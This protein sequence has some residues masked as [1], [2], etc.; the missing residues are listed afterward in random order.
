MRT[1]PSLNA[2]RAFDAAGRLLSFQLAA[3]ELNVTPAAISWQVRLLEDQLGVMLFERGHRPVTLTP[4]GRQYLSDIVQAFESIRT[5]TINLT[6]AG[7]HRTLKIRAYTTFSM[8]WLLPR[9]T[10]FHE[11]HPD[12]EVTLTTS[13]QPVDFSSEDV[14]GAIR[15][16]RPP[17][18]LAF[19][20]LVPNRLRPVCS[21]EFLRMHETLNGDCPDALRHVALLHSLARRDD[22]AKWLDAA[23]VHG[24]NPLA[25]LSYESSTLAYFGAI[26]GH[27]VAIA[28][29]V[30]VRDDLEAGRLVT[31]FTFVLDQGEYTYHLIY[32]PEHLQKTEFAIFR[33]WIIGQSKREARG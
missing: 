18:G 10:T 1:L 20:R 23:G 31:P 30:L 11:Q 22:W 3:K 16:S 21:P 13:L 29:E 27:G 8:K 5:S 28:Q 17:V 12:I 32:P 4:L 33:D 9:L 14:D 26:Q 25:G 2:L 24:V 19:D 15:L 7:R 6:E